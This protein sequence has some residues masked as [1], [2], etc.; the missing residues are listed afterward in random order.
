MAIIRTVL[1]KD[2]M[3]T[4]YKYI[5][6]ICETLL[7]K[8]HYPCVD[9]GKEFKFCPICGTSADRPDIKPETGSMQAY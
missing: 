1:A 3:N 8:Y 6:S 2:S 7:D 5:C 9:G 4:Y